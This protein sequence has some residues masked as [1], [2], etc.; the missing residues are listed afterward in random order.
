MDIQINHNKLNQLKNMGFKI[1]WKLISIGLHGCDRIPVLLCL[2]EILEYL[3]SLLIK[4]DEQTDD[5]ISLICEKDDPMKFDSLIKKFADND[6]SDTEVQIRKWRVYMLNNLL[7]NISE[8]CLQGL[9]ELI[10][11]WLA[12]GETNDGPQEL[13]ELVEFW[14]TMGGANDSSFDFSTKAKEYFS[15][16]SYDF[17]V[18][19]NYK[20]LN[21]EISDIISSDI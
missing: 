18:E 11:F 2:D 5:I 16:E 9:L 6:E 3:D 14:V 21:Q 10:E 13:L 19:R 1:P 8:D 17:L 12:M 4:V 15:K 20:W 7:E